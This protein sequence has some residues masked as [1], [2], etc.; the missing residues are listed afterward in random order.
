MNGVIERVRISPNSCQFLHFNIVAVRRP[1]PIQV[2]LRIAEPDKDLIDELLR[3]GCP[4][5][6]DLAESLN[7]IQD[8]TVREK[9]IINTV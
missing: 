5:S 7:R 2:V 4:V 6:D 8:P 1:L 3:P 9:L